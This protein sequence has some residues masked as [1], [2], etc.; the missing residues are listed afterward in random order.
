MRES[1]G[2]AGEGKFT[3]RDEL[4]EELGGVGWGGGDGLYANVLPS[5]NTQKCLWRLSSLLVRGG[6]ESWGNKS[7]CSFVGGFLSF[8][9]HS[10][11]IV[12]RYI[13]SKK[14]LK[15]C[16]VLPCS[17]FFVIALATLIFF[18]KRKFLPFSWIYLW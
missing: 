9:P 13:T 12:L 14:P 5:S 17:V 3:L 18:K 8:P 6:G 10:T 11:P 16:G 15:M 4:N 1:S 7:M 2:G